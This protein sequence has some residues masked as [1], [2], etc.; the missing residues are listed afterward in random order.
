MARAARRRA[1][2]AGR[3]QAQREQ[4]ASMGFVMSIMAQSAAQ[5]GSD[6][7]CFGSGKVHAG[8]GSEDSLLDI[9][10]QARKQRREGRHGC[11]QMGN[12]MP[13]HGLSGVFGVLFWAFTE[14]IREE[15][16]T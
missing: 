5:R 1:A 6:G 13:C 16:G 11:V 10:V 15:R 12:G 7:A 4:A 9:V 14:G 2:R 8:S 3:R